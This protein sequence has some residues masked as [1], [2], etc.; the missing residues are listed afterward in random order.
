MNLRYIIPISAIIVLSACKKEDPRA[1]PEDLEDKKEFV[2]N[3]QKEQREIGRLIDTVEAQILALDPSSAPELKLIDTIHLQ[4]ADLA[5]YVEIQGRV[6]AKDMGIASSEIGGRLLSVNGDEGE[7]VR[8][9][10]LLATVDVETINKQIEE[11]NTSLQLAQQ[12]YDRQERLWSQKIGSEIQFLQAKNQVERLEQSLETLKF[13]LTKA[14]VYSPI[15]GKIDMMLKEAGE[16]AG[17]GEPIVRILD[18]SNLRT[19]I[20][21]PENY[22]TTIKRGQTVRVALPAIEEEFDARVV[23]IGNSIDAG[24]RTYKIETN[25]PSRSPNVKPNLLATMKLNDETA[26][27]VISIPVNLVQQEVSGKDYVYILDQSDDV[28]VAKKKYIETGITYD[29][30]VAILSG[31]LPEDILITEGALGLSPDEN[32]KLV[33]K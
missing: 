9:G 25:I 21:V 10:Q 30:K 33:T 1:I 22:L 4:Y 12:T 14:N 19:E 23:L 16:V 24:S 32:V 11:V 26:E 31:L 7:Y 13:Q 5:H 8:K 29:G 27:D 17:P 3:M 2:R 28:A 20:D 18:V 15:S 6:V